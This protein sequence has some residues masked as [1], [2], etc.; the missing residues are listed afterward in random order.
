MLAALFALSGLLGGVMGAQKVGTPFSISW[1]L[2][3][4]SPQVIH[5]D[6]DMNQDTGAITFT[7]Q[8][9]PT[10]EVEVLRAVANYIAPY[11][12]IQNVTPEMAWFRAWWGSRRDA[13]NKKWEYMNSPVPAS[14]QLTLFDEEGVR[15]WDLALAGINDSTSSVTIDYI[16]LELP[17]KTNA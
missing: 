4:W 6:W 13:R 10:D 11:G 1:N 17:I 3:G 16:T 8:S 12:S 15:A 9:H 2:T 14:R 7:N 5:K